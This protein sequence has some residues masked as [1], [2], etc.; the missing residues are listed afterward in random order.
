MTDQA[1]DILLVED[2][3]DALIRHAFEQAK[4]GS[5]LQIAQDGVEAL[6]F[7]F[8]TDQVAADAVPLGRPKVI[9]L[10][11][12]LPKV[13]GLE[14]LRRLKRNPH[15]HTIPAV[16]LSSSK[17]KRDLVQSHETHTN[18]YRVKPTDFEEFGELVKPRGRYRLQL[19]QTP[20][21]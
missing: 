3:A 1:I 14:L 7:L 9:V 19:N 8:G 20:K 15:T 21:Q 10:D 2:S 4:I 13:N 12:N 16:V 11:I 6:T 5:R 17:T 18:S